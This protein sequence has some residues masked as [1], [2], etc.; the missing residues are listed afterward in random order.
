[1]KENAKYGLYGIK[2]ILTFRLQF[3]AGYGIPIGGALEMKRRW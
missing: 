3:L 2:K 1:L